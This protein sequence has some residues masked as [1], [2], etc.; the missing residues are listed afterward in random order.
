[1]EPSSVEA[2]PDRALA[3]A[4]SIQQLYRKM[5]KSTPSHG[6]TVA[7]TNLSSA[8][9]AD[10]SR[11]TQR[12]P[13]EH[14]RRPEVERGTYLYLA[15]GS[16]LSNETF[17]G[18]RGIKPLSQINVQVPS[19]KLTFDLPGIPYAEPC[20]ANSGARD[21]EHDDPHSPPAM[22]INN[23][24]T[25][26]L[27]QDKEKGG[28]RKDRWHKGLIGVV[29]EVTQEDYTH[30][31]ATEGGGASYHDV[32][33]DCHP[34]VTA[35]PKAPVPDNPTLP[36]FK[37]HTLFAPAAPPGQPPKHGGRFQRSDPAYAQPSARY[38][39][40]IT[41]GAAELSLPLE[42]QDYLHAIHPYTITSAKQRVGQYVFLAIWLPIVSFIFM[43]GKMFQDEN[44]RLPPWM[45]ELSGAIFKGVWASYDSFFEPMFGDGERSIPD[46]G[47]D[48]DGGDENARKAGSRLSRML[49]G[50]GW[51]I[52]VEKGYS[53]Q[54]LQ[55]PRSFNLT[56]PTAN[57]KTSTSRC[58]DEHA[59][60][61]QLLQSYQ[62]KTL[63]NVSEDA[64]TS[65]SV[66]KSPVAGAFDE[67]VDDSLNEHERTN[68][69]GP[70]QSR[71]QAAEDSE[72]DDLYGLSPQG[73]ASTAAASLAKNARA[74]S[75]V[76]PPGSVADS[77]WSQQRAFETALQKGAT[78]SALHEVLVNGA[79]ILDSRSAAFTKR[80]E[81]DELPTEPFEQPVVG[82]QHPNKHPIAAGPYPD[83]NTAPYRTTMAP[84][85]TSALDALRARKEEVRV[86]RAGGGTLQA[87]RS[88][89]PA[90][91][92]ALDRSTKR[93]PLEERSKNVPTPAKLKPGAATAAQKATDDKPK[94]RKLG[95]FAQTPV[96]GREK[97][98]Q[99][100]QKRKGAK[101]GARDDWDDDGAFEPSKKGKVAQR[102]T[103]G[104]LKRPTLSAKSRGSASVRKPTYDMP[105]SPPL[106]T[107]TTTRSERAGLAG[108]PTIAEAETSKASNRKGAADDEHIETA[109]KGKPRKLVKLPDGD[110]F[111]EPGVRK[112][113]ARHAKLFN[114]AAKMGIG[115]VEEADEQDM[116]NPRPA[117]ATIGDAKHVSSK[118][119]GRGVDE[120]IEDFEHAVVAYD[121]NDKP[122]AGD[123]NTQQGRLNGTAPHTVQDPQVKMTAELINEL[124][125]SHEVPKRSKHD[126]DRVGGSQANAITL[127]DRLEPSSSV[128][129]TP[130]ITRPAAATLARIG[131]SDTD[132]R[133]APQTPA[134]FH[135][136]PPLEKS[137]GTHQPLTG[138]LEPAEP[139]RTTIIS[140]D[141][142]GPHNQGTRSAKKSVIGSARTD[143]TQARR[144][145][146]RS[147]P[148]A[149]STKS[150]RTDRTAQPN[151]VAEDVGDAL[152]GFL[153]ISANFG[154][155]PAASDNTKA[156]SLRAQSQAPRPI[157]APRQPPTDVT[158][159]SWTYVEDAVNGREPQAR[160]FVLAQ[161]AKPLKKPSVDRTAS[162]L[163]MPP[164]APKAGSTVESG[165]ATASSAARRTTAVKKA[166]SVDNEGGKAV[167]KSSDKRSREEDAFSHPAPK[168]SKRTILDTQHTH[169]VAGQP[170]AIPQA[171]VM[172]PEYVP[173]REPEPGK[174]AGRKISRHA[175]QG[176]DINGSPIP[177]N[178]IVPE[179]AT[180]L[181]TYNQDAG[182]SPDQRLPASDMAARRS[183]TDSPTNPTFFEEMLA[184][185]SHQVKILASNEKRRPA[186]PREDSQSITSV[187]VGKAN[188]KQL[189]MR[190]EGVAP[191][192]DPFLSS[193][194]L[195]KV[196]KGP[197]SSSLFSEELRTRAE[198]IAKKRRHAALADEDEDPD[199][200]LV[201]PAPASKGPKNNPAAKRIRAALADEDD[202]DQTLV[203]PE[204]RSKRRKGDATHTRKGAV[205]VSVADEENNADMPAIGLWRD[206]L[207]PHQL[208]LFD[209]LVAV[210]HR[211]VRHLVDHET[212][213]HE[214]VY[215][216]QRRGLN[217]IE[218]AELVRAQDYEQSL[219]QLVREKEAVR[220][221][222][223][224]QS[225]RMRGAMERVLQM[226]AERGKTEGLLSAEQSRLEEMLAQL[227]GA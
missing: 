23:E 43:T 183:I 46:G 136:S 199:K 167:K 48:V 111:E 93:L 201:E 83:S 71:R 30:I 78:G 116:E 91:S 195:R 155:K 47:D 18:N 14:L 133:R 129:S 175:S 101:A 226:K 202:T 204:P 39:K 214:A 144:S 205:A 166:A 165:Q 29:Y 162:Q 146:G 135:S 98:V 27:K 223:Q 161:E 114:G 220:Q 179:N 20:F 188:A 222:L 68:A 44:G 118:N 17:R 52:D 131:P 110:N 218:Q 189:V 187:V 177:K 198:Q 123:R 49:H 38:L 124:R 174:R 12:D 160:A 127:S 81:P 1:M 9:S 224:Q 16:N 2:P 97:S 13:H 54:N 119:D 56:S 117:S 134:V 79:I 190:D 15:Y 73:K 213:L 209:E 172:L 4:F 69:G 109:Q 55:L 84:V 221:G 113:P 141:R 139:R 63:I 88:C 115:K 203:E 85:Y 7:K 35:D 6:S 212:A 225:E 182:L 42:Y 193:E 74:D 216:Y 77:H 70:V 11:E 122:A 154:D 219:K 37:A 80:G 92:V 227:G 28:Y 159:N 103:P 62:S 171:N 211:L 99:G 180:T 89:T 25:P 100:T 148:A 82:A 176:V 151:N 41:D 147:S 186:S 64:H 192:T 45:V 87:S 58:S 164:P 19:L 112:Q 170:A 102:G 21:A 210:S 185:P 61:A 126:T 121:D 94:S 8:T 173:I 191:P 158:D 31:I 181:E 34:F 152:A 150:Y 51:N 75:S 169:P 125:E 143:R 207:R 26:L 156:A 105:E 22:D 67:R 107:E 40:L 53:A 65:P 32:L 197:S 208:N 96:G 168:K 104:T 128:L 196:P 106:L 138:L 140:F 86:A 145:K 76:P 60:M 200:T 24:K 90:T 130:E 72:E 217:M 10:P 66:D 5:T 120:T 59:D 206:A 132:G 33:V 215:D 57:F 178:M 108:K 149:T 137:E 157:A 153:K 184:V 142:S 3:A 36:A 194:S 50:E 163:A 95:M